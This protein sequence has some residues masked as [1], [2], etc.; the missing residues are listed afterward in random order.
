MNDRSLKIDRPTEENK[1]F[2]FDV[3]QTGTL[4]NQSLTIINYNYNLFPFHIISDV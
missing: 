2:I 1:W 3:Q 4:T